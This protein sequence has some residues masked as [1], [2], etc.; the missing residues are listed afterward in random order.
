M[1]Q[2]FHLSCFEIRTNHTY[3]GAAFGRAISIE[4]C[5]ENYGFNERMGDFAATM[6]E[7]LCVTKDSDA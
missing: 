4:N 2:T 7:I 5:I 3:Y 1:Q 6:H